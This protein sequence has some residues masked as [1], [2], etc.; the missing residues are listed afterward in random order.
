MMV[1]RDV[2]SQSPV[3]SIEGT[4]PRDIPADRQAEANG[5]KPCC[6]PLRSRGQ[7]WSWDRGELICQLSWL[8][9]ARR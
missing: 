6:L 3:I 8:R 7:E 4:E 5:R 9:A 1:R 2:V